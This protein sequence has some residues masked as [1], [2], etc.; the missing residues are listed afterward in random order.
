MRSAVR[1]M[2]NSSGIIIP[3]PM[4]AEIGMKAGDDV[5]LRIEG[6]RL[7]IAVVK[8][9]A[10]AGWAEDARRIAETGDDHLVLGEFGND[11]DDELTW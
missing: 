4:L 5:D 7:I 9:H 6:D 10:R 3:K 8:P 11:G 2:G 1:K